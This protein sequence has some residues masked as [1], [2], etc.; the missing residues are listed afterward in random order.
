MEQKILDFERTLIIF[1]N[2]PDTKLIDGFL[3]L[4]EENEYKEIM[5]Y[6]CIKNIKNKSIYGVQNELTEELKGSLFIFDFCIK[7]L[8]N[9]TI[10]CQ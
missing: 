9:Q 5:N 7:Y 3:V 4:L 2:A 8:I 10:R 1:K 6:I